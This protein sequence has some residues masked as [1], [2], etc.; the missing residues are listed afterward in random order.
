MKI[1]ALL[2][3]SDATL[4]LVLA[5]GWLAVLGIGLYQYRQG[6][7]SHKKFY[8]NA[9]AGVIWL[10]FSLFQVS[11]TLTGIVETVTVALAVA[12]ICAGVATGVGWWRLRNTDPDQNV[13]A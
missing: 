6:S 3:A 12:L 7:R 11:T 9:S 2:G 13:Q 4:G 5:I 1:A 8:M 10:A